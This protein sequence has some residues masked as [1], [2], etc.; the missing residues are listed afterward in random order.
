MREAGSHG[1]L[2]FLRNAVR[3]GGLRTRVQLQF[4]PMTHGDGFVIEARG[5]R[6]SFPAPAGDLVVLNDVSLCACAGE[7]LAIIGPS[8]SGKST[9]LNILGLLEPPTAGTYRFEGQDVSQCKPA[10]AAALRNRRIGFVFQEHH[11]L[12]QCDALENVL[13]PTLASGH[14]PDAQ[15]RAIN[16]LEKVGLA[17]RVHHRPAEL[18]GGERQRVAIAR[19]LIE[20]PAVILADEPTGNLDGRTADQVAELLLAV[21]R[22]NNA[23]LITVT[24]SDSLASRFARRLRMVDGQLTEMVAP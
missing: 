24:H 23:V 14:Q 16:L 17:E 4:G 12:P 8:G 3:F 9:L 21:H 11:L 15:Q 18:S 5:L 19:A 20:S 1:A 22:E 10:Q 2:P 7:S 13:I 6:K